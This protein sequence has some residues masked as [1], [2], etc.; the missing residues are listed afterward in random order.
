LLA[1]W[2]SRVVVSVP[3]VMVS[4]HFFGGCACESGRPIHRTADCF[5][6]NTEIAALMA[7]R[8]MLIISDGKDWTTYVPDVEYPFLQKVYAFYERT[9]NVANAHLATEGHDYGPSKRAAMYRFVA[10]HLKLNLAAVQDAQAR[11]TNPKP[12]S[13]LEKRCALLTSPGLY[14]ECP[15]WRRRHRR[16][17][18]EVSEPLNGKA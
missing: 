7:P 9:A 2:D 8:P 6:N 10:E 12:P 1:Q 17:T 18:A 16:R 5:A 11:S 14:P 3:V 4:A 13:K 15:A